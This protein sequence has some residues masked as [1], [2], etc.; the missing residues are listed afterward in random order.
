MDG[1]AS[2]EGRSVQDG[3]V[4]DAVVEREASD[5]RSVEE[6]VSSPEAAKIPYPGIPAT[7]DGAEAVVHVE[8]RI[9]QAAGAFPITSSTTMRKTAMATQAATVHRPN[10]APAA[11]SST[12]MA[13]PGSP[14]RSIRSSRPSCT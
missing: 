13:R 4:Q 3:S 9:S 11:G 8:I 1:A 14:A 2:V 12:T 5:P 6:I 7:C 10:S